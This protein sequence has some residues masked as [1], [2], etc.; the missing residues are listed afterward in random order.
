L[1]KDFLRL[2]S[3]PMRLHRPQ[4]FYDDNP[5]DR[6]R[7]EAPALYAKWVLKA[8]LHCHLL[9]SAGPNWFDRRGSICDYIP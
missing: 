5:T 1:Y 9:A 7:D 3:G 8:G 2:I 6:Q 4:F